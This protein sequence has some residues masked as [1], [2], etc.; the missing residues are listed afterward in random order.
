MPDCGDMTVTLARVVD[1]QVI[2]ARYLER[3]GRR[4]RPK[5]E[6]KPE[7]LAKLFHLRF[8]KACEVL[9]IGTTTLKRICR[10]QGIR[11]W[12]YRALSYS[13]KKQR[14]YCDEEASEAAEKSAIGRQV[15][16]QQ[17]KDEQAPFRELEGMEGIQPACV[18]EILTDTSIDG[19]E[20]TESLIKLLFGSPCDAPSV[21]AGPKVL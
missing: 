6:V 11:R 9:G 16:G 10:D 2:E 17:V 4:G 19:L 12:P 21:H 20:S 5:F 18:P 13:K 15:D 7:Q 14:R 8:D 3:V 1:G